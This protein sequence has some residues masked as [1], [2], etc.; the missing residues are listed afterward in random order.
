MPI[1]DAKKRKIGQQFVDWLYLGIRTGARESV[2]DYQ[3]FKSVDMTAAEEH[4]KR[5]VNMPLR[6]RARINE[7]RRLYELENGANTFN[8]FVASCLSLAGTVTLA[9]INNDL[10]TLENYANNL[11]AQKNASVMTLDQVA[12]DIEANM[13]N[14]VRDWV[15][16]FP[17]N[18]ADS[19]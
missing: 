3:R 13:R 8:A 2:S 4:L 9:D 17:S 10:T 15:F 16:P 12:A 18:Y 6:A 7:A 19:W 11:I 1:A 14:E 5:A